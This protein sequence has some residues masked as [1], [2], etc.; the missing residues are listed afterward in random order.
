MRLWLLAGLITWLITTSCESEQKQQPTESVTRLTTNVEHTKLR[1]TPGED[2]KVIRDLPHGTVL[3]DIGEVSDFTTRINLRGIWFEEPW[4]KVRAEDGTEGWVY[5]GALSF[6]LD[7]DSKIA[8]ILMDKRLQTSFGK[9]LSDSIRMYRA[10]YQNIGS[11]EDFAATFRKGSSL[12]EV[13]TRLMQDR[14]LIQNPNELPDLFWLREAM[15]G[16]V[17]QLVAEGTAYYLFWDFAALNQ[18]AKTTP[19]PTDD[20]F[21]ALNL[22]L[23]PEDSIEY[24]FP[25]WFM[26]TWDYG[27]SSLLGRGIHYQTLEKIDKLLKKSDLFTPELTRLKTR[28]LNDITQPDVTYWE[29]KENITT[30][31]DSIINAN[32]S[33]LS[34][35]D[36]V[37]LQTRRQQFELPQESGIQLNMQSGSY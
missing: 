33:V 32:F 23:F 27:G 16:M 11:A 18:R 22:I 30:E 24:F 9:E 1:E 5:G 8:K 19:E 26:Q 3:Q 28:L 31:L 25:A 14:I 7:D 35:A 20:D 6:N 36:K 4:L 13:M 12:R 10:Q 17:P 29:K 15:P 34:N 37:A 21:V 2:G